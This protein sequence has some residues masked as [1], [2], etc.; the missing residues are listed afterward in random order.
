MQTNH[1]IIM[2]QGRFSMARLTME[3]KYKIQQGIVNGNTVKEI[4]EKLGRSVAAVDKYKGEFQELTDRFAST[5]VEP[6]SLATIQAELEEVKQQLKEAQ[7]AAPQEPKY[8]P[9]DGPV[10]KAK[11]NDE[12]ALETLHKLRLSGVEQDD[13]EGALK[14]VASKLSGPID[15]AGRLHAL[16][17]QQL[18]AHNS[19]ITE[20]VGGRKGVAVM[21]GTASE[22]IDARK[23]NYRST[24]PAADRSCLYN[25][26]TGEVT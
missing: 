25:P 10:R 1:I 21:T 9:T 15:D 19:M 20:A 17:M 12:V 14:A 4:A 11:L 18:S 6:D 16:C 13:A 7:A 24:R 5:N 3:E 8:A 22:I 26:K 2:R 23:K